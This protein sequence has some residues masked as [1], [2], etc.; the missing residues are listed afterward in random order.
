MT[1]TFGSLFS[2]VGGFD[3]GFE[4]AGLECEWQVEIDSYCSKVLAKHWPNVR[5]HDDVRTFPPAAWIPC[6]CCDNFLCT[7]HGGHAHDCPEAECPE[8][9]TWDGEWFLNPYEQAH[10]GWQVD[11]IIGGDP[12]Q[13]NSGARA[14]GNVS[15]QSLGGEFIR[16]VTEL[17]P[18]FVVRENPSLIRRD[19][20]WPWWRFRSELESLGYAVLPFRLR[21]CCFGAFH[22]RERV[23][24]LGELSN[25]YC[26]GLEGRKEKEE[27][28]QSSESPRRIHAEE[29]FALSASRGLRSRN[30]LADYVDRVKAIGNAVYPD[31]A[32][33]I[34]RRLMESVGQV[35]KG[36]G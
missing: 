32:E 14:S 15:Q 36:G 22:R 35:A 7:W 12:C 8:L 9:E 27:G 28:G 2:G 23:F 4:R 18:R 17:R 33:W 25:T 3:L 30:E 26:D 16:I 10:P 1:L 29:W 34:G 5:R 11:C 21:A 13:E 31:V 20:P 6:E 19:A 24:L